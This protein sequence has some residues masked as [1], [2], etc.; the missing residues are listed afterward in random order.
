MK[1]ALIK[2]DGNMNNN[3]YSLEEQKEIYD[4]QLE[5]LL[6]RTRWY[7]DNVEIMQPYFVAWKNYRNKRP[8]IPYEYT[9]KGCEKETFI[10][11]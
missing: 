6:F 11:E 5:E 3:Q 10:K 7:L 2:S 8:T 9:R 4:N 1:I